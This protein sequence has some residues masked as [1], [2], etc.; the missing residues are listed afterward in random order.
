MEAVERKVGGVLVFFGDVLVEAACIGDGYGRGPGERGCGRY[1]FC[2]LL[3][4]E[5]VWQG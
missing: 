1:I 4:L 3:E 5:G 2:G